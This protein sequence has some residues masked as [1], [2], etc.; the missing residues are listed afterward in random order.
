V[1]IA[2]ALVSLWALRANVSPDFTPIRAELTNAHGFSR[3]V[4]NLVVLSADAPF[5]RMPGWSFAVCGAVFVLPFIDNPPY[6]YGR[7]G[8]SALTRL[9]S[10]GRAERYPAVMV[11]LILAAHVALAAA[12]AAVALATGRRRWRRCSSGKRESS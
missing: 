10:A 3:G 5:G 4:L 12:L 8:F 6:R 1:W 9:V 7:I 2:V 11:W